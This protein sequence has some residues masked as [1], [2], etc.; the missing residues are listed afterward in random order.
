ML[1]RRQFI[2]KLILSAGVFIA[3]TQIP[4]FA[5]SEDYFK[6]FMEVSK[7]LTD[8]DHLDIQNG[9]LY[10][11]YF[12]QKKEQK[13]DFLKFLSEFGKP[14]YDNKNVPFFSKEILKCWYSGIVNVNEHK[15][16]VT[17]TTAL[18]W[19]ATGIKPAGV[20]G[21]FGKW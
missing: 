8:D 13:H 6:K 4:I 20:C 21:I 1:R 3:S 11:D 12:L 15:K 17:Y 10:F 16:L 19:Q 5:N 14:S 7:R 2:S 18:S 9:R